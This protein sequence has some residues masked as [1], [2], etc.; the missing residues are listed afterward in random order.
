MWGHL[1]EHRIAAPAGPAHI[2]RVATVVD[3]DDS[4]LPAAVRDLAQLLLG[5]IAY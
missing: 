3:G 1:A 4:R 5:Q 2:G